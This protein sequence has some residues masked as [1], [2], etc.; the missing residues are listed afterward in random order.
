MRSS[1]VIS[2]FEPNDALFGTRLEGSDVKLLI[3]LLIGSGLFTNTG[4]LFVEGFLRVIRGLFA[5]L[6]CV[7]RGVLED[8]RVVLGLFI[9][10]P[11][12]GGRLLG[13]ALVEFFR[14]AC[15]VEARRGLETV[16]RGPSDFDR[17]GVTDDE[18]VLAEAGRAFLE[19]AVGVVVLFAREAA[20]L[21]SCM[22]LLR[23]VT[24]VLVTC[25]LLDWFALLLPS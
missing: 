16:L 13:E 15:V 21:R 1:F 12:T 24:L 7:P 8:R 20:L 2:S 22:L 25:F 10:L 18:R 9:G 11:V 14:D 23:W 4:S 17:S 6:L 3:A 5:G 19:L